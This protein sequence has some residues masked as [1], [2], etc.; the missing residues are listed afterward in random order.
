MT[1]L[2]SSG[3][4]MPFLQHLIELRNRLLKIV[5]AIIIILIILIPF[6]NQLFHLLAKPLLYFMEEAG[7]HMVAIEV[8]GPFL[9]PFKL[10]LFT[11]VLATMPYTFYHFWA[12]VAPG[13]YQHEKSLVLPLLIASTILFYLGMAFAYFVV[14]PL[15]FGFM[16]QITPKGVEMMTDIGHY[17]DF[18]LFFLF[19]FGISFQVPIITIVAIWLGFVTP[20]A[21]EEKRSHI[22]VAAFVIGMILTPP[23]A[24]SQILLAVPIWLLFEAG[25]FFA[26]ILLA[27]RAQREAQE[28]S[29][30]PAE[31]VTDSQKRLEKK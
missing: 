6:A 2:P 14:F 15:I 26:K 19:A 10:A 12:F 9:T 23:D 30:Y 13:L 11:A 3:K 7:T 22:I 28:K 31:T 1:D 16:M 5:L 8:I 18:V 29:N 4:E 17:L 24:I 27:K 25:L 20:E 21:L